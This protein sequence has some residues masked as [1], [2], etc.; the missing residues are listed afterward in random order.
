MFMNQSPSPIL[1]KEGKSIVDRTIERINKYELNPYKVDWVDATHAFDMVYIKQILYGVH[2]EL[3]EEVAK[4][5][6]IYYN[7][8]PQKE[9]YAYSWK[10]DDSQLFDI[11]PQRLV[12][13]NEQ[14]LWN[15][16]ADILEERKLAETY[17]KFIAE[18]RNSTEPQTTTIE[19]NAIDDKATTIVAGRKGQEKTHHI[20]ADEIGEIFTTY[21]LKCPLKKYEIVEIVHKITGLS[22]RTLSDSIRME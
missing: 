11:I 14:F 18:K 15:V 9:Y 10:S 17:D 13:F 12:G 19:S 1:D 20:T 2:I 8:R 6:A 7:N 5:I 22:K 16:E 21:N 3:M 4:A